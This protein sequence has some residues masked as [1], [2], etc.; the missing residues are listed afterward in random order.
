M[1]ALRYGMPSGQVHEGPISI[2][3]AYPTEIEAF[4][5]YARSFPQ[6]TILLLDT[7]DTIEGA[8]NAVQVAKELEASGHRL[9]GVRLDSGDYLELSK[10]VRRILDDADLDAHVRIVVNGAGIDD[11][12]KK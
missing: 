7:Y 3:T 11:I 5:A 10:Q 8:Y 1:A 2:I 12:T 4:R 6:R 9:V